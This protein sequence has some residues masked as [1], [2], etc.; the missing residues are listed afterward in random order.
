MYGRLA[1]PYRRLVAG[2][3][4]Q[5][6]GWTRRGGALREWDAGSNSSDG[7]TA[8]GGRAQRLGRRAVHR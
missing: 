8:S 5:Q 7:S 2:G 4:G 1:G 6:R 3:Q